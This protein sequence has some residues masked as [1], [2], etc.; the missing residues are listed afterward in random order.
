[1]AKQA[2]REEDSGEERQISYTLRW[3]HCCKSGT[4][5]KRVLA[6]PVFCPLCLVSLNSLFK[7]TIVMS[8][9]IHL[10]L[11][12]LEQADWERTHVSL[13]LTWRLACDWAV[14]PRVRIEDS[15][16]FLQEQYLPHHVPALVGRNWEGTSRKHQ[17]NVIETLRWTI[18]GTSVW[19]HE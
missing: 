1:M 5:R 6:F 3:S 4:S 18:V 2:Q 13:G 19:L 15:Q 8:S 12:Q 16:H 11:A 9:P 14:N 10:A 7:C 17:R